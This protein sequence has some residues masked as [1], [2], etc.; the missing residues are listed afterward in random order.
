MWASEKAISYKIDAL[1]AKKRSE[2]QQKLQGQKKCHFSPSP[3]VSKL[4]QGSF[5]ANYQF[6]QG[7]F[8]IIHIFSKFN[9][10][11]AYSLGY[12]RE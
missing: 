9:D 7:S 10:S 6:F 11:I 1:Q 2:Q 4:F 8:D 5:N 12:T 3:M